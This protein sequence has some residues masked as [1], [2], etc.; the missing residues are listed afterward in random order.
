[1][2]VEQE[3]ASKPRREEIN[4]GH[5]DNNDHAGIHCWLNDKNVIVQREFAEYAVMQLVE[6]LR[7]KPKG[8]GFDCRQG[9]WDFSLTLLRLS[10]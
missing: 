5:C 7:Y 2:A 8:R 9:H 4:N 3:T 1:M 10:L 6:A